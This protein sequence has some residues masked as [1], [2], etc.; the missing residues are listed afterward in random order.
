MGVL[1]VKKQC[2][3]TALGKAWSNCTKEKSGEDVLGKSG[4]RLTPGHFTNSKARNRILIGGA[5][6]ISMKL[7]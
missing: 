7:E 6:G 2:Q 4:G 5:R 3:Q 1:S